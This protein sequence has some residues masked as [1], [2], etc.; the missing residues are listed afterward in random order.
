MIRYCMRNMDTQ[1]IKIYLDYVGILGV[2]LSVI[3]CTKHFGMYSTTTHPR[4]LL[5]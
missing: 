1:S 2:L 4:A 5:I 3:V